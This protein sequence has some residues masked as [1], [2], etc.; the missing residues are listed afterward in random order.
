MLFDK[1]LNI[2]NF[3]DVENVAKEFN[4]EINIK[5]NLF[6]KILSHLGLPY[7]LKIILKNNIMK[8]ILNCSSKN[9]SLK[10]NSYQILPP[11]N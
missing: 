8:I 3:N 2:K 5:I 11:F 10:I 4:F 1:I 7:T 9:T 6:N